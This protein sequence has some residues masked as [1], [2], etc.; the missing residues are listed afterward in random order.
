MIGIVYP[1][2]RQQDVPQALLGIEKAGEIL[3]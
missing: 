2:K 1:V 3:F